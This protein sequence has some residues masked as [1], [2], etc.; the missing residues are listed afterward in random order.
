MIIRPAG[1]ADLDPMLALWNGFIRDTTVTFTSEE[2][3]AAGLAAMIAERRAAGRE[4]LVAEA[5]GAFAGFATYAQ[6]RGGNGYAHAMEH[7]I[8]LTPSARGQ[9]IGRRLMQAIEDHARAGGAH[10][11]F[12]GVSGENLAGVDFHARL[13]FATVARFP[14]VGRKFDRW[15]DL[16]LMMKRL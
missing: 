1:D 11:L 4:F 3:T 2:K 6:F 14:E 9:G 15:I 10:T 5:G 16:V 7:S 12:A 8:L 13:G